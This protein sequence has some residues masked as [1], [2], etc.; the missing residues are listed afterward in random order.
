M[1]KLNVSNIY[2]NINRLAPAVVTVKLLL[3]R[4]SGMDI[5]VG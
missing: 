5:Q 3:S 2:D 1:Q 4:D